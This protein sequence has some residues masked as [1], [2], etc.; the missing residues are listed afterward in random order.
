MRR[1][2]GMSWDTNVTGTHILTHVLAPYL[3]KSARPRLLFMTSGLSSMSETVSPPEIAKGLPSF[4]SPPAGWPKDASA[5]NMSYRSAK[6][7][8]NMLMREWVRVLGND[9]VK[10]HCVS[11]GLLATG[12]GG[13]QE[14]LKKIGAKHPSVGAEFVVRVVEGERDEDVGRVV[15]NQGVIQGW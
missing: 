13:D 15:R 3:I 5:T 11:P 8:L 6:A 4:A 12:L 1:G 10:V 2:F 9:G 14:F 7:G